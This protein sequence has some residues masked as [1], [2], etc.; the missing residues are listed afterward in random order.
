MQK[1]YSLSFVFISVMAEMQK[2]TKMRPK[3]ST[4]RKYKKANSSFHYFVEGAEQGKIASLQQQVLILTEEVKSQK[5]SPP[6]KYI[7][8]LD[9]PKDLNQ[10]SSHV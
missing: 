6:L 10:V 5:V 4:L 3:P 9:Q 7:P 2:D 1:G 8:S